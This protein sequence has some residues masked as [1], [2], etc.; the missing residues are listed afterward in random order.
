MAFFE[1][2]HKPSQLRQHFNGLS[3]G[4]H[5][6]GITAIERDLGIQALQ[7]MNLL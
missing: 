7:V 2:T 4:G 3:Q 1:L 6:A 5:I